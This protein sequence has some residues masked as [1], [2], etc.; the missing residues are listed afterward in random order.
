MDAKVLIYSKYAIYNMSDKD[1]AQLLN[2][3]P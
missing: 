1:I 3:T 2:V